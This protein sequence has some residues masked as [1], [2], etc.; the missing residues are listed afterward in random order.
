M[1]N[2]YDYLSNLLEKK[3]HV[4]L[5]TIIETK[6]STPQV[7]GASAIFS[8]GGLLEGTLGGGL[9][10][11]DAQTKAL[12]ALKKKNSLLYD[13]N[14]YA[15]ISTK[16]GAIC[17]G[18][19]KILI[20]ASPEEH[21]NT[22]RS[23][24]QSFSQRQ[25]GL[26]ATFIREFPEGRASFSRHWVG[27]EEKDLIDLGRPFSLFQKEIKQAFT[28]RKPALLK[29]KK[30][31]GEAKDKESYLFLEP[32]F[33]LPQLVVAGAGHIGKAVAHLGDL[34]N[35]EVTVID[36]RP[37][38]AKKEKIPDAD[39][40]IM[41]EIGKAFKN[42]SLSS[43]TFVVIVTRGHRHDAEALRESIDSEASYIG[44]I[45][46]T[47]KIKLMRQKFLEEGWA[48]SPQFDRVFAPIG[49]DIGSKTV[50]EIAVSIAAQL[51]H[52]RSQIQNKMEER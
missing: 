32:V 7:P 37:E 31:K 39:H 27:R 10:E 3:K 16:D 28:E 30:K 41:D 13:F 11:A 15:D 23:L 25:P 33:P 52:V 38:F 44:M 42:F 48:T 1:K 17:G 51:V 5:A 46:S 47:R 29:V 40:I 9:L 2:V 35:F 19:V 43:D 26:L 20:D 4:A 18:K 12:H 49:I 36:D 34:L 6:G 45:G 50:E 8:S 21:K 14:L 22:F 24:H